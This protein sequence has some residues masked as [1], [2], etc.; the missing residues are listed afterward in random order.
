[1]A[2][3]YESFC[4][5]RR[6]HM[7]SAASKKY[8]R[9][10]IIFS[11]E[12]SGYEEG[13]KPSGHLML[14]VRDKR[15]KLAV[16]IQNLRNGSGRFGYALYLIRTGKDAVDY[17]RAGKIRQS[18]SR[19]EL[20]LVYE[21]GYVDGTIYS[22]DDFDTFA[23]IVESE[24]KPG[25]G[26]VCPLAAYRNGRTAW[27]NGLRKAMLEKMTAEKIQKAEH[28]QENAGVQKTTNAA[29]TALIPYAE[30]YSPQPGPQKQYPPL[31]QNNQLYDPAQD[32]AMY[33][34]TYNKQTDPMVQH[35]SS[36]VP[37]SQPESAKTGGGAENA[38]QV[39][40]AETGEEAEPNAQQQEPAEMGDGAEINVQQLEKSAEM[41]DGTEINSQ[42]LT[43]A[44]MSDNAGIDVQQPGS[45]EADG[46]AAYVQQI[47]A[48]D[49][50]GEGKI[51]VNQPTS[52]EVGE[53]VKTNVQE[54]GPAK[55]EEAEI[56]MK[57]P[58]PAQEGDEAK[59]DAK[60]PESAETDD[61][62]EK[63]DSV[64][65]LAEYENTDIKNEK[66]TADAEKHK[67][68]IQHMQ[69]AEYN[70]P[71]SKYDLDT[72][73]LYLNGNL[74]GALLDVGNAANPCGSCKIRR[75]DVPGLAEA[76]G[77]G[78]LIVLEE[79]LD[80]SFDL[81]DP[82]HSRR[83]DYKWWRAENPVNLNNM[84]YLSSIRSPLMFNQAVMTAHYKYKHLI[85]GI[86][87]HKT[88]QRYI[89]CGVPGMYMV[90]PNPFGEMGK[91]VQAE[92]NRQRYGAFGYWLLYIDPKDGSVIS[93]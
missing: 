80:R 23:V 26:T 69:G 15:A 43:A 87:T 24:N 67:Q 32:T 75:H 72:E 17:V 82:F 63:K 90:D 57:Q 83:S 71:A 33:E 49:T 42:Q 41:G 79:E 36:E 66:K 9:D 50:G 61:A 44:E 92:G 21:Q 84:F 55:E 11:N 10:F 46:E 27:R 93:F 76:K 56:N 22:V 1:M 7:G 2:L 14:E 34:H 52:A 45:A 6:G 38:Q 89:I 53:E 18:D 47:K 19:A 77:E 64:K 62:V 86:F 60:Q 81:C 70:Y 28:K 40:P 16:V 37:E 85:I 35:E 39:E 30:A 13:K 68:Q 65:P 29:D 58:E 3:R 73:C 91:W 54:P 74:C 25:N 12:D 59:T 5:L 48:A 78:D 51:N 20:E 88:G 31:F 8:H 4:N